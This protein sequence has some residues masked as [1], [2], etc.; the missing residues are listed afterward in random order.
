MAGDMPETF[1]DMVR[2]ILRLI[3]ESGDYWKKAAFYSDPEVGAILDELYQRW[4][5]NDRQ[6]M[7]LDYA[8]EEEVCFLYRKATSISD[9]VVEMKK[10]EFVNK[11]MAK[12]REDVKGKRKRRG[13]FSLFG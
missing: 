10:R 9:E 12:D 7:P 2:E 13:F 6:G 8:S 11:S 4:E 1:E 3:D 5:A